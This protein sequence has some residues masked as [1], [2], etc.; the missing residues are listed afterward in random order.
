MIW[1]INMIQPLMIGTSEL[2][3]IAGIILLF[4]GAKKIPELMHSLGKGIK[5]YKEG[6][7]EVYNPEDFDTSGKK[8]EA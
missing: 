4:F 5:S 6:M 2:L 1:Y 8:D 7:K 3:L